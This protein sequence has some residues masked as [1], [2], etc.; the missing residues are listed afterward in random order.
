MAA[1]LDHARFQSARAVTDARGKPTGTQ[2]VCIERHEQCG[3]P[4]DGDAERAAREFSASARAAWY[5][6]VPR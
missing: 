2:N 6:P 5:F 1:A 3:V 4:V